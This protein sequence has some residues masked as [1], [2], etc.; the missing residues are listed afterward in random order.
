MRLAQKPLLLLNQCV[1]PRR[2]A[3][4]KHPQSALNMPDTLC[5]HQPHKVIHKQARRAPQHTQHRTP[6]NQTQAV[7]HSNA[8]RKAPVRRPRDVPHSHDSSAVTAPSAH[9]RAPHTPLTPTES[10]AK[11]P[12]HTHTRAVSLPSDDGMLPESWFN[13]KL[14]W[15]QNTRTVPRCDPTLLHTACLSSS[16]NSDQLNHTE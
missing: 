1:R 3:C 16:Y 9:N 5:G 11:R 10:A 4:R 7:V 14:N 8:A 2:T 13:S 6:T 12:H 15:L